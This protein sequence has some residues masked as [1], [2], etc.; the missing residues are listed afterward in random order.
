MK[1]SILRFTGLAALTLSAA[2]CSGFLTG[3]KLT[4]SPNAATSANGRQI[5]VGVQAAAFLWQQSDIARNMSMMVQHLTGTNNQQLDRGSRYL[6]TESDVSG[7][8]NQVYSFGGLVSIRAARDSGLAAGDRR[9]AGIA[10]FYEALMVGTA[11]S[12]WGDIPYS[13][14]LNPQVAT[15]KLDNQVT[16]IYPRLQAVLDSAIADFA[17]SSSAPLLAEDVVFN[18]NVD[19][20]RRA[21]WSLKARYWMHLGEVQGTTAYQNALAATANGINEVPAAGDAGADMQG[22][23][24][25]RTVHGTTQD[26]D[27]NVWWQ[28]INSRQDMTAGAPLVNILVA[29]NDTVRLR[30]YFIPRNVTDPALR[31][32]G[33]SIGGALRGATV[34]NPGA[35]SIGQ[36]GTTASRTAAFRQPILTWAETQLIRAEA[37]NRLGV[38]DLGLGEV[39]AVRASVRLSP[40][41]AP[42]TLAQVQEEKYVAMYQN[43]EAFNDY[44]RNCFPA[45][46][47]ST[48]PSGATVLFV[49][50]GSR[51]SP[52]AIPRRLF[53]GFGERQT[54]PNIPRPNTAGNRVSDGNRNDPN[55]C[56]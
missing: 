44:K 35:N 24:D 4:E 16:E 38:D 5:L 55:A 29:R 6:Y 42:I 36:F 20:W 39:N 7:F 41:S 12:L 15:P 34:S 31:W 52:T 37:E 26:V 3:P 28:F 9:L 49:G 11:A 22:A 19:R 40:L 51:P 27:A 33:D 46:G 30:R 10:R 17:A 18:G 14:T 56:T 53:Y 8:F 45:L 54:N 50:G 1:A 13:E 43:I 48:T 23:G 21:A 25:F 2:G 32:R 47:T